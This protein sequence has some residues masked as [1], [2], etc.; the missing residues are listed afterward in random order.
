MLG[1]TL[2]VG[3]AAQAPGTKTG[4]PTPGTPQPDPPNLADRITVTGCLQSVP[5]PAG[6]KETDAGEPSDT[7]FVLDKVERKTVVPP[8]TGTS[9][10]AAAPVAQ[11]LRLKGIASQLQPFIGAKV[12]ISGEVVAPA[13]RTGGAEQPATL[14]VEFAQ[15]LAATCQ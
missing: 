9:S 3:L 8:G 6:Q 4:N 11:K 2:A 12:E 5:L 13:S 10:L 7:R 1:A 14:Q 15:K